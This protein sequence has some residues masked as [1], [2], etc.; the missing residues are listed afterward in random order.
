MTNL[1]IKDQYT[2]EAVAR[3]YDRERFTSLV[4]RTFD[5]LEKRAIRSIIA[6]ACREV[7]APSVLDLPCG[8]GRI[9]EVLLDSGLMVKGGDISP[10]MMAVARE[11]CARFGDRVSWQQLDLDR[12]DLEDRSVDLA[13]CI[14]LFH[15]LD[16]SQRAS[17]LRELSRVTRRYVVI[18]VSF[19]SPVY[20]LRR[21]VKRALGQGVSRTQ[22]TWD[23][24]TRE[25]SGA[26]LRVVDRRFVWPLVSED[27]IL[28]LQKD[29]R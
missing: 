2:D 1:P 14:R 7:P 23:D 19:S 21:R 11:R 18:N 20:R 24:I 28:L 4:G 15:H 27:L 8:T 9:T 26:G 29:E 16:S 10:A 12:L 5:W 22:A 6:R 25:V 17:I 13:T 3:A